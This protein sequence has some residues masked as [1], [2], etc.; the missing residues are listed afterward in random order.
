[1]AALFFGEKSISILPAWLGL[2]VLSNKNLECQKGYRSVDFTL[3]CGRREYNKKTFCP[4]SCD[5]GEKTF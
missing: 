1:M 2:K 3:N 5:R 4:S